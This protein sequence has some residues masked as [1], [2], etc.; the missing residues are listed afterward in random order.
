MAE[1]RSLTAQ[2]APATPV[3]DLRPRV[4]C[5]D[6][7]P[8]ILE[9]LA[10]HLRRR[11]QVETALSGTAGLA[12]LRAT[13]S[14][15]AVVSDMRMPGMD[16][17][18]FLAQARVCTPHAVRVL[19]TGQAELASAI[20]AVNEG[21]IFRFLT[22]PCQP[23]TLLATV[24]A[25][26]GQHH[27]ITA[28][29]VLLEQTLRGSIKALTDVLAL[30]NP[31][32]FGKANRVQ[33]LVHDIARRLALED[34]WQI[35]MAAM[36]SQLGGIILPQETV[37]KLYRSDPLS[38]QETAMV[39]R[40]PAVTEQLLANI[41]RLE[42]V[43]AML[44][45]QGKPFGAI[46]VPASEPARAHSVR[47][48]QLLTVAADYDALTLRGM[49]PTLIIETLK[50][51]VDRYDPVVVEALAA[52][53]GAASTR[54]KVRELAAVELRAGMVIAED[55]KL[56]TGALVVAHGFVVTQ[57]FL[58]RLRNFAG[59]VQEPIRIAIQDA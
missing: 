35:E 41:P 10:L 8:A 13:P 44:G 50:G 18:A 11:Y 49:A 56:R 30:T 40:V 52:E 5:V 39:E 21:Q 54:R 43:R 51:R 28:E 23:V 17:A 53:R 27:L 20:A 29:R 6:D 25:A 38:A 47:G 26:I 2:A 9:G 48:A 7:E 32:C 15:A 22:K 37:E 45:L 34:A 46:R 42:V 58:E 59:A 14:I 31:A 36:L 55:I 4:L 16:G 1:V 24:A 19:L 3:E 12:I 33:V 57:S